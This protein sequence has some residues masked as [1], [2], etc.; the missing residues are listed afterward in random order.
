M[1]NFRKYAK[2]HVFQVDRKKLLK[3]CR[4]QLFLFQRPEPFSNSK[5]L[6]KKIYTRSDGEKNVSV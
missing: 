3:K 6:L 4:P 1:I 5:I 2:V